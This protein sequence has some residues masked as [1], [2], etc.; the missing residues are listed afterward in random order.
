ML[1]ISKHLY[2]NLFILILV[3]HL[4]VFFNVLHQN[5]SRFWS[6]V[7]CVKKLTETTIHKILATYR[8]LSKCVDADRPAALKCISNSKDAV[9]WTCIILNWAQEP[10]L[11]YL[12]EITI[13][14]YTL[15]NL[16]RKYHEVWYSKM[17]WTFLNIAQ[18][19]IKICAEAYFYVVE[20]CVQ[21]LEV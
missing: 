6:S 17:I 18:N 13:H 10:M 12:L 9:P 19:Q 15:E 3:K 14:A 21:N 16:L 7:T 1:L 11:R 8:Q 5:G 20:N 4:F 2:Q